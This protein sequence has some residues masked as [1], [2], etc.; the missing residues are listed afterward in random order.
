MIET[1]SQ[2][3]LFQADKLNLAS[4]SGYLT[5]RLNRLQ[6]SPEALVLIVAL[7]IGGSTSLTVVLFRYLIDLIQAWSFQQLLGIISVWGGW[8]L[9]LIPTLGGAIVGTMKWLF[10]QVLGQ[11]FYTLLKSTRE[12]KIAPWRPALKMLA[13][14]ISLGTGAS[15]GPE[16]PSVEIGA[17]IGIIL[18][19]LFQVSKDRYRLLLG[20]GAAAGL[21][22]G[23]NAPIAGVFFALEVVLGTVFTT[24][25]AS[26][27]LLS[28]FI[29]A[30]IASSIL[31]V[32]PALEL[33]TYQVFSHWEWLFYLGLGLLASLVAFTYT[34]AIKFAQAMFR[35]EVTGLQW[36]GKLP[37]WLKPVLGG[38][39]LGTVALRLPQVL[40]V[41]YGTVEQILTGRQF[42]LTL[43][44]WLLV[45]KLI[46]TAISLGSGFVGGVFA[47]A[48][49]LGACLGSTYGNILALIVP[50]ELV[51]APPPAYAI[52]GM[53][54]VLA[55]SVNA[56][57]TAI[58]LLFE[59]TQNYS[60]ILP[61]MAAVGVSVWLIG[62]IQAQQAIDGLN[63]QQM[64]LNLEKQDERKLLGQISVD[65]MM[66]SSYLTLSQSLSVLEA[67]ATILSNKCH[68][69]LV[70]DPQEQLVGVVTLADIQ[71]HLLE[72]QQESALELE[73]SL[74]QDICTVEVLCTYPEEPISSALERMGTRGLYL[75]PVV[76][77]NNPRQILGVI[78]KEQIYLAEDL[79]STQ[80]ALDSYLAYSWKNKSFLN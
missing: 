22:A 27:I 53:A 12:Q 49:F 57:L 54:A 5:D 58:A 18:A 16:S 32:H 10:P 74:L 62:L 19:Q 70:I 68:T 2:P 60:I 52:V 6:P 38:I 40:G 9:L 42:S 36:L 34:Q 41:D 61:L 8:T 21:A 79:I 43:L 24:P 76:E 71:R 75:L 3:K 66:S 33:P 31:G 23:F 1:P 59:L 78:S 17:N 80:A 44:F 15:L 55:A 37:I 63:L 20:A 39:L 30:A 67:G 77:R 26:L 50:P 25:A 65:V 13:A 14:S 56:P 46:V 47:P 29:S 28:A 72:L 45:V 51:I 64:G 73:R 4:F 48:I 11:D 35:G 7:I 69:A